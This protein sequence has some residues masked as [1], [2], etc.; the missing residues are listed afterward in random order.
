EF[1]ANASHELKTPLT[2]ALSSID[3][4]L[5]Q[6]EIRRSEM[7]LVKQDIL[8]ID[9]LIEKL[10]LLGKVREG[11]MPK[12]QI[13]INLLMETIQKK[14]Y[15]ELFSKQIALQN[16]NK[17]PI[18]IPLPLEYA[19][20]VFSNI[21]SNAIKYSPEKSVVIVSSRET[22]NSLWEVRVKDTGPGIDPKDREHI[23]DRFY[24]SN[25]ARRSQGYGLG[26]SLVKQICDEYGIIVRVESMVGQG[27]T[28]ILSFPRI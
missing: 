22:E 4:A 14:L 11:A 27:S 25:K 1:I 12:G 10:L 28:F 23:F 16:D 9:N 17:L 18:I 20:I 15:P 13:K 7:D 21:I 2:R 19:Q 8:E 6:T 26:L 5:L 3:I 24:R